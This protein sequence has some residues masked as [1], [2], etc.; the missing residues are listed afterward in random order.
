MPV[1][2]GLGAV[3]GLVA[4]LIYGLLLSSQHMSP[5][6]SPVD[7]PGDQITSLV[8]SLLVG[9][10]FG[11]TFSRL[12]TTA[13]AGLIWGI[14]FGVLWWVVGPLTLFPFVH[15]VRPDWAI[16]SARAAF[17]LL[18]GLAVA[19]GAFMGLLYSVLTGLYQ[20]RLTSQFVRRLALRVLA[21][22]LGGGLAGLFGGLAFGAWMAQAGFFPLVA[23]LVNSNSAE[24]GRTLHL[25]I[26]IAIGA[27]YGVLFRRDIG[28]I[29][30]S[31]AWGAVYGLIWWVLGPLTLMP[32]LLGQGV[33]WNIPAA[34]NA[35]A[36]LIG[37]VIYGIVLGMAYAFLSQVW[38]TLFVDSDP[39]SREPEG[40]GTRNL[41]A[42]GVGAAASIVGGL[43][44]TVVMVETNTL[45]KVANIVG[46]TTPLE[47]FVVHMVISILIGASYGLLFRRE[48][49]SPMSA[50]FWG[51][52]YGLVWWF[53]GPLTLFPL[54]LGQPL[55]WSLDA[56]LQVYPSLVGHL[57]YGAGLA[58]VYPFLL[59]RFAAH[60]STRHSSD[61]ATEDNQASAPALWM[62]MLVLGLLLPLIL[63]STAT[64]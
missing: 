35:F 20:N 41:R 46:M 4:G 56:A 49:V 57:A 32:W 63:M 29:G 54:L 43:V 58:L 1:R 37:H 7:V 28:R 5:M 14:V 12:A 47:G 51:I 44:F 60:T 15:G 22:L 11:L 55:Q 45:P 9:V 33:Q 26:S 24:T 59:R 39:L 16:A 27:S 6:M 62:L 30:S 21:A 13:G 40:P 23:G 17:P 18:V 42:I 53:L 3:A 25:I 48:A 50:L 52:T 10:G 2:I 64:V 36:S 61:G 38:Q 34:Q 8:L 19:Y 31:I